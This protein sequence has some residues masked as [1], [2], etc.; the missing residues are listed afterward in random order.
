VERVP[1]VAVAEKKG[2]CPQL[3][4]AYW[5]GDEVQ[6][7]VRRACGPN[8]GTL[9]NPYLVNRRTGA[10][11]MGEAAEP[12]DRLGHAF[13]TRLLE[14]AH[15][16]SLSPDEARCLALEGAKSLPGWASNDTLVS[17]QPFPAPQVP[18]LEPNAAAFTALNR[19]SL[20]PLQSA[21][22]LTVNLSTAQVRDDETGMNLTSAGLGALAAKIVALRAPLLLTDEEAISIALSVPSI[23]EKIPEGCRLS[24][25]GAYNSNEVV[26]GLNCEGHSNDWSVTINLSTGE[27]RDAETRRAI[28]TTK[29]GLLAREILDQRKRQKLQLR[30]EVDT[31]CLAR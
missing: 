11:T 13:A 20:R 27:V 25:G 1:A 2:E 16:R 17:V 28:D 5:T 31:F 18:P 26:A 22:L 30:K 29:V 14:L 7:Q 24:G 8:A 15:T 4:G 12:M 21:R 23:A 10:V 3:S 9:I 19:P 6:F